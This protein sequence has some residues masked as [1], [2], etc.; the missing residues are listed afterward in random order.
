MTDIFNEQG[1]TFDSASMASTAPSDAPPKPD[2]PQ[3]KVPDQDAPIV[4]NAP[5]G[6]KNIDPSQALNSLYGDDSQQTSGATPQ[7][8][9]SNPSSPT[10]PTVEP[11]TTQTRDI[12][13]EQGID[14]PAMLSQSNTAAVQNGVD[15][16]NPTP[17]QQPAADYANHD[18][19]QWKILAPQLGFSPTEI[20]NFAKNP[21]QWDEAGA[22]LNASDVL[23][24]GGLV[25]G[26]SALKVLSISDKL[27]SN[28]PLSNDE[29][30][31]MYSFLRDQAEFK[32]R[33]F[34][35]GGA[36][37]YY[38]AQIPAFMT[39]FALAA[40]GGK[41][42]ANAAIKGTEMAATD[43]MLNA[44][45]RVGTTSM[46]MAPEYTAKYGERRLTDGLAITDKGD[47]LSKVSEESP[48]RS[49]LLAYTHTAVDVASMEAA[50]PIGKYLL[51]PVTKAVTTPLVS[52]TNQIPAS[53]RSA[54]YEAYKAVEPA[55]TTSKV[56][57]SAGWRA[58]I[59]GM[60]VTQLDNTAQGALSLATDKDYT[61]NDFIKQINPNQQSFWV[62]A[63]M[64]GVTGAVHSSWPMVK[65]L[66]QSKGVSEPIAEETAN[67]M[68]ALERE[69]Y[70]NENLPTPKSAN[71]PGIN[72]PLAQPDSAKEAAIGDIHDNIA[73]TLDN[74]RN[75][76]ANIP[77]PKN[78][79]QFLKDNGGLQEDAGELAQTGIT[80]KNR[81]G[82]LN[83][84]G[85]SLDD[86]ARSAWEAGYF[87][88]ESDR[89]D[90]NTFLNALDEDFNGRNK[91]YNA[92]GEDLAAQ[93]QA[94][95]DYA[96][97]LDRMGI[98][99]NSMSNRQIAEALYESQRQEQYN[100]HEIYLDA[101]EGTD[102]AVSD[103]Q[104]NAQE[105]ADPPPVQDKESFFNKV[106]NAAMPKLKTIYAEL[107]NVEQPIEDLAKIAVDNG[108]PIDRNYTRLAV[109]AAKYTASLIKRNWMMHTTET[110]AE[111]NRVVTGKSIKNI[112]DDF[113]N[114]FL[115]KEPNMATRHQDFEDFMVAERFLE[116]AG[117]GKDVL[118]TPEQKQKSMDDLM[119]LS[120]KYGDDFK[121]FDTYAKEIREWDNRI[122]K[123]LVSSGLKSQ[124]WYDATVN[125]RQKYSPLQRIIDSTPENLEPGVN[126]I[127]ANP[128]AKRIGSLKKFQGSNLAVRN[129]L[130]SRLK[131]SAQ[132]IKNSEVNSLRLKIAKIA[133]YIPGV[134]VSNPA[135]IRKEVTVSYDPKLRAKLNAAIEAFGGKVQTEDMAR[136]AHGSYNP[137]ENLIK[138][139]PGASDGTRAHELGHMIDEKTG[140]GKTMLAEKGV[141][142]ELQK[143]ALDRLDAD[144]SLTRDGEGLH[145][146][147]ESAKAGQ[148]YIDYLKSDPEI[149]AN[150]FDAYVH[151]PEQ[152]EAT[153]PKARA[154]FDKIIDSQPD[155]AFL[156][157]I[158]PSTARTTEVLQREMLDMQGPKNSLPFW[159]NG[160]MKYLEIPKDVFKAFNSLQP[161]EM[162][163]VEKVLGAG[164]RGAKHALQFGATHNLDFMVRHFERSVESAFINTKG[165]ASPLAFTRHLGDV[166]KG[167]FA[168]LGRTDLYHE[169]AS[170][171]SFES[172][173]NTSPEKLAEA[174]AALF[175]KGSISNWQEGMHRVLNLVDQPGRIASY[176]QTKRLGGSDL[177]A[178]VMSREATGNY[179]R[180]GSLSKKINRYAPFFNDMM[181]SGDRFVRSQFGKGGAGF[182]LRC[183]TTIMLPQIAVSGYYLF[184]ADDKTRKE[185]LERNSTLSAVSMG[186]KVGDTWI[187]LPRAFAP[188]FIYG[189]MTESIMKHM[190][191]NNAPESEHFWRDLLEHAA[192]SVSPVFDWSR[193]INPI[194]KSLLESSMNYSIFRNAPIY[195]GNR[196]TTAPEQQ[197][198]QYT[199]ETAKLIGK[200]FGI[201]PA[202]FDNTVSDM[203]GRFGRYVTQLSDQGIQAARKA[204]GVP[205][206]EKLNKATDNPIYGGLISE[207]PRGT[208]TADYQE[209]REHLDTAT[210]TNKLAKDL[211]GDELTAFNSQN[212][213]VN[214][215]YQPL[216]QAEQ[217]VLAKLKAIKG[218]NQNTTDT[219]DVKTEK[220][221]AL[222]DQITEIAA[223]ANQHYRN[224]TRGQQ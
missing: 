141:R 169:W 187:E 7:V 163:M 206:P 6:D 150:F 157:E 29:T 219:S 136:N 193:A 160:K 190:F 35:N 205:V 176:L 58:A 220:V 83:Q 64:M 98:D 81:P 40:G 148:K 39:E 36:A 93:H 97:H 103:S 30:Q 139:R 15:I 63:G 172:F 80:S 110:N 208:N 90:V 107:W 2:V 46:L 140:L 16:T 192:T 44:A 91:R 75:G 3:A 116:E 168:V 147:Q 132:I 180:G 20:A 129:T 214:R 167:V 33:G 125:A 223:R 213:T 8:Q 113:D 48:L 195:A 105:Q 76:G 54:F 65:G 111:D 152:V 32:L 47:A 137:M 51:D 224:A 42:V 34:T 144:I 82:L 59:E 171:G 13:S 138:L 106:T 218:I 159:E 41:I 186:I 56:L 120:S 27:K 200:T 184:A 18:L 182:T 217:Q 212:G 197:Y 203:S 185:Y 188:G 55:A 117:S 191:A 126:G 72:E 210:K 215:E 78:L 12:F 73:E 10:P 100:S 66:L 177:E 71:P 165:S 162:G 114:M 115:T 88:E 62:N 24:G 4:S 37:M 211:K 26:V 145:Y 119:R 133:K 102:S 221:H 112:Y 123:N 196:E 127:G 158:K 179:G 94:I 161:V 155:L 9:P 25:R 164:F 1:I 21:I 189:G 216:H 53:I 108:A 85:Q 60:S 194:F 74:V 92:D 45:L 173:L 170:N 79:T 31:T 222:N 181:Q 134:E 174:H 175:A 14:A 11:S 146:A 68:S 124:A 128:D 207:T 153:A 142:E 131:N 154:A 130:E 69:Q 204:E 95:S 49:A 121:F 19:N 156:K 151:S 178:G 28:Q 209:F 135:V 104:F 77:K 101:A 86:A 70:V 99:V 89:P 57:T 202:N 143:L 166:G 109:N 183:V 52:A 122:L 87:P 50:G 198:N 67:N 38:G 5:K 43:V 96:E 201:S 118:V 84:N 23:P 17:E 199:S 22:M 149:I 61:A